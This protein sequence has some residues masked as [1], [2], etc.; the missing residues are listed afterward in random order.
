MG[1]GDKAT[2]RNEKD[3]ERREREKKGTINDTYK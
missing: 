3:R 1:H 2:H